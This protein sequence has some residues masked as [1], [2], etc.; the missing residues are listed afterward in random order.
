[1]V[2]KW[3]SLAEIGIEIWGMVVYHQFSSKSSK[4]WVNW[5]RIS[6][7][8]CRMKAYTNNRC[9]KMDHIVNLLTVVTRLIIAQFHWG[10]YTKMQGKVYLNQIWIILEWTDWSEAQ[11]KRQRIACQEYFKIWISKLPRSMR[12]KGLRVK[13]RIR[14]NKMRRLIICRN[15]IREHQR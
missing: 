7:Q 3:N 15:T 12:R 6:I 10:R 5:R 8:L 14:K 4:R 1:M 11:D 13:M 9:P 2:N